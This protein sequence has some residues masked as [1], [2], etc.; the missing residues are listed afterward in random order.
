[1]ADTASTSTNASPCHNCTVTMSKRRNAMIFGLEIDSDASCPKGS[2]PEQARDPPTAKESN[3]I[4]RSN[5]NALGRELFHDNPSDAPVY[6]PQSYF[7]NDTSSTSKF[8]H[9]GR[10]TCGVVFAQR[11]SAFVW[12]QALPGY[13]NALGWEQAV[14]WRTYHVF[15]HI[16]AQLATTEDHGVNNEYIR[17]LTIPLIPA[18]STF[19]RPKHSEKPEC[20][21][22]IQRLT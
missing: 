21:K 15:E 14:Q 19:V 16:R 18:T 9:I 17:S 7:R 3:D 5:Y 22:T 1:M 4:K 2:S 6:V 8:K 20:S 13:E 12:K 10:G 11:G